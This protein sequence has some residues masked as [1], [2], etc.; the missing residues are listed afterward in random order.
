MGKDL[1][2]LIDPALPVKEGEEENRLPILTTQLPETYLDKTVEDI[3]Q[4]GVD[5]ER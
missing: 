5:P 4:H 3:D 2:L 1:Y